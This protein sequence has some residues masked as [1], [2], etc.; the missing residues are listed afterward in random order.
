MDVE[1]ENKSM[2]SDDALDGDDDT[3]G[4]TILTLKV[5]LDTIAAAQ[6]LTTFTALVDLS[7]M[8]GSGNHDLRAKELAK[9][10]WEHTKYRFM[11]VPLDLH[12]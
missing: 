3:Q 11:F 7:E 10:I 8:S 5:F 6:N 9:C 2:A 1:K 12:I 4:L